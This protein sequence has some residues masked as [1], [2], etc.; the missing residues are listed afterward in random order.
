MLF[1]I[2]MTIYVVVWF[3]FGAWDRMKPPCCSKCKLTLDD[4]V[5]SERAYCD[6]CGYGVDKR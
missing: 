5:A 3:G 4:Y 1:A 6:R 2:L